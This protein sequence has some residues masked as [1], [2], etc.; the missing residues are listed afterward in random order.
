M[1]LFYHKFKVE[2]CFTAIA[3]PDPVDAS[4]HEHS[5]HDDSVKHWTGLNEHEAKTLVAEKMTMIVIIYIIDIWST[6]EHS[7]SMHNGE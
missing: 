7:Y 2:Q 1:C 5:R 4:A 3:L 6:W